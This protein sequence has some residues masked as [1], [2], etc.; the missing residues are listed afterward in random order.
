MIQILIWLLII[1]LIV[2]IS[3]IVMLIKSNRLYL[4]DGIIMLSDDEVYLAI[5]KEDIDAFK[6]KDKIE[7][8]VVRENFH[9]F[10]E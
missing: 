4:A 10:S 8:K 5:T 9:G 2:I 3:L 1:L 6:K 7:I